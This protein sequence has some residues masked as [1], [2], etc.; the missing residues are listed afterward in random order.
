LLDRRDRIIDRLRGT[1]AVD[2]TEADAVGTFLH[3]AHAIAERNHVGVTSIA[4]DIAPQA[5]PA[6][7]R[8]PLAIAP[9]AA[10]AKSGATAG[11]HTGPG[12]VPA[13]IN[14]LRM[15]SGPAPFDASFVGIPFHLAVTGDYVPILQT[16]EQLS[17][18]GVL[19]R[20]D[21]ISLTPGSIGT[22]N[23]NADIRLTV[24][25]P[26]ATAATLMGDSK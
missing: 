15:P 11:V 5:T 13:A 1:L 21:R 4:Q 24:F 12:L 9:P 16:I 25:R 17:H 3:E 23:L 6:P 7:V 22:T 8:S 10:T 26:T 14:R 2:A 19:V 18:A 20:V